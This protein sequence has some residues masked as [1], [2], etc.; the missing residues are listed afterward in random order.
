MEKFKKYIFVGI[1]FLVV[2]G[3]GYY[4]LGSNKKTEAAPTAQITRVVKVTKGDLNLSVSATGVVQPINKVEIRSKA[5]GQIIQLTFEEGKLVSKGDLLIALDQTTVKNE[6]DQAKAD[7]AVAEANAKQSENNYRRSLELFKKKLISE[8]D[9]DQANLTNVMAKSQLVRAKAA[10][11]L[12][13]EK[14]RD[15]RIVAPISGII[16]SKNVEL[17]Q[18]IASAVSNV[19]GGTLLATIADMDQVYVETSVDEVDIG[20]IRV[21][22][23]AKV[24]ADPFPDDPFWGEVIR[25]APLGKTQQNVTT[26]SVIVLVKNIGGKLK[27]GMSTTTEI[28][29]FKRQ[30]VLLVPNEALKDPQSEQGRALLASYKELSAGA[31][32]SDSI[33]SERDTTVGGGRGRFQQMSPEEREKAMKQFAERTGVQGG[34]AQAMRERFQK[35]SPEEREKFRAQMR[36]RFGGQ[37]GAPGQGGGL[38]GRGDGPEMGMQQQRRQS[39][40]SDVNEV[41][42][43]IVIVKQGDQVAPKIIKVGASNFDYS[44]VIEGLQEGDEIQIATISRAKIASQEFSDRMRSMN[45]MGGLGGGGT[46]VPGVR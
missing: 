28:E 45:S 23:R 18:I 46:R 13:D 24:V 21:G 30:Q 14:L 6:Y 37:G 7:L 33:K 31:A 4:F 15:T 42:N 34:D 27:A 26:F 11:S 44:E 38:G 39:Q 9:R 35:M 36:Q 29:V 8:Q 1:G 2:G 12:A 16:L 19:G 5:S 32:K 43:R 41:K 20:R 40:V 22:Q 25:I 17:G 3:V 10:L